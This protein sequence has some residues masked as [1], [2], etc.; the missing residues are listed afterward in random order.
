MIS[1]DDYKEV[2]DCTYKDE[3]YSARDNGA[4]MRHLRKGMR[5]RKLD[6]VWSFGTPNA[7]TGYMDFCGER[8]HR[9]VAT[10]FHGE[11]PSSQHVVDHID[12]NRHNNR[13]DNLR[14][15]TKLEN[16][17]CNEITRKKVELICGSVEAFLNDPTLLFGYETEDK[18]FSWMK[19]VTP[20]EAKNCLDN[21]KHWAKTAAPNPNYKKEEHHVGDWI[22]DKPINVNNNRKKNTNPLFVNNVEAE[23]KK[24]DVTISENTESNTIDTEEWLTKTSGKK[25]EIKEEL[26]NDGLSDSL[27]SSAKQRY[28]RT[29]TEFPCCPAEVTDNGLEVYKDNLKKGELF[30]SNSYAKYYVIDKS[31]IPDKNDLIVLCTNNEGEQVFGAYALCSVKIEKGKFVHMSIRRYG[32]KDVATHYFNLIIGKEEWTEDD[33]ILWDT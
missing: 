21:W 3:H 8:V 23:N 14:W 32:S 28:W 19:S 22:F 2:K 5:K 18:N 12:T 15:L 27:T 4:I 29:P 20:E 25:G 13:P 17:L 9:I 7:V 1:V 26:E 16:I 33:L 31:I 30:S 11:A 6:E 24:I 10:A